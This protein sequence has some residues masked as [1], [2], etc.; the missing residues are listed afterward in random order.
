M[1]GKPLQKTTVEAR[2]KNLKIATTKPQTAKQH[3]HCRAQA[4]RRHRTLRLNNDA[5]CEK[6]DAEQRAQ[7]NE[8]KVPKDVLTSFYCKFLF[9]LLLSVKQ[10]AP[11]PL[12]LLLLVFQEMPGFNTEIP[13]GLRCMQCQGTTYL[14]AARDLGIVAQTNLHD[15][16]SSYSGTK[17]VVSFRVKNLRLFSEFNF[18]CCWQVVC[19]HDRANFAARIYRPFRFFYF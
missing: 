5:K 19:N 18:E 14:T 7:N 12:N 11:L 1:K 9:H 16:V 15:R 13:K 17:F 10:Q 2:T 3:D 8:W 4:H 6:S